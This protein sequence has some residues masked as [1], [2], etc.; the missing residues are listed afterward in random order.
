MT[1]MTWGMISDFYLGDMR[2]KNRTTDSINTN[3]G[4]LRR[5][6]AW[7]GGPD[8]K[9]AAAT[10]EKVKE[11]I[12]S[13]QE[14]QSKWE[15]HPTRP[16]VK[17]PLSP[18]TVRKTVKILRG[19]GTWMVKNQLTN[20]FIG[21]EIPSV[22]KQE[23]DTLTPEEVG[24]ILESI[25]P[26]TATG[27]RNYAMVLLMLDTGPRVSEVASL[28]LSKLDPQARETRVM[29][30]G[31]KERDVP[32]GQKTA[33]ALVRYIT[34][35]RPDPVNAGDDFVFLS[36]DGYPMTRNAVESVIRRLRLTSGVKKLHAYL[37]RH[38]FAVN[39]IAAGGDL[40]T[41]RRILGH[42][43]LEVTQRYLRGLKTA[44]LKALYND[45]SPV[46]RMNLANQPRRFGRQGITAKK[47]QDE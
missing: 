26:N 8:T 35:F 24:K 18:H 31:R 19:V 30:K 21:L 42:E 28:R 7:L 37:L 3:A 2:L 10:P 15:N 25:N 36:S 5:F 6:V 23:I 40:E 17:E 14:R 22:P 43:S 39:F 41:L 9:L 12:T 16:A 11:Y 44:Q 38:T 45:F 46:D 47:P 27:A 34:M 1:T 32:F 20:P 33:Q 13:Q 4:N 29:G